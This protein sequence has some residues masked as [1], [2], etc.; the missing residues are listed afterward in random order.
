MLR[1]D[2]V[3]ILSFSTNWGP[4]FTTAM[5]FSSTGFITT[6]LTTGRLPSQHL[7]QALPNPHFSGLPQHSPLVRLLLSQPFSDI[8]RT[9]PEEKV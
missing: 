8:K 7:D 3:T 5:G 6:P 2:Q 4:P 1:P 9:S